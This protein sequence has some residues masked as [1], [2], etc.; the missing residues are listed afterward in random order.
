MAARI[1]DAHET[2]T[3]TVLV[4]H[5]DEERVT[6]DG[7]PDPASVRTFTWPRYDAKNTA[8]E[9]RRVYLDRVM[10]QARGMA[11]A[12]LAESKDEARLEDLIG[13]VL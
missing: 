10:D 12:D 11:E 4:V 3:E 13:K 9:P 7:D 6:R 2:E 8:K 5:L 1:L